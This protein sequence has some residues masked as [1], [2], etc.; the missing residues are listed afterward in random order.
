MPFT[1]QRR[2]PYIVLAAATLALDRWTKALIQKRFDLIESIS[3]IDGFFN[4]TYVRNT[5][6]ALAVFDPLCLPA[7]SVVLSVFSAFAAV[8]VITSGLP[9]SVRNRRL[10]Y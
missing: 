4:I 6:V 8:V 3:V 1:F 7:K 2:L 10:Q 5:R 9:C